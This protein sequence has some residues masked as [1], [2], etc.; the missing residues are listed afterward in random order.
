MVIGKPVTVDEYISNFSA[1][2]RNILREIRESVK[3]AAPQAVE[4]ISY[5]APAFVQNG[6][7]V[8]FAAFKDHISFFPTTSGVAAF[9]KELGSYRTSKGTIWLAL[10][11]TV[12]K[13]L[14]KKI[15][16]FRVNENMNKVQQKSN[17]F[18]R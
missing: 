16:T 18:L 10:D 3:E 17:S 6:I 13:E 8:Y 4:K 14:I 11:K 7:L 12:P 2:T 9:K 1:D 5:G 15:V